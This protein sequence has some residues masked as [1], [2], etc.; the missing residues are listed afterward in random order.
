MAML[1]NQMV[2]VKFACMFQTLPVSFPILCLHFLNNII[3]PMKMQ[4]IGYSMTIFRPD[5]TWLRFS[6]IFG[7]TQHIWRLSIKWLVSEPKSSSDK[8]FPESFLTPGTTPVHRVSS[9]PHGS[10]GSHGTSTQDREGEVQSLSG[11]RGILHDGIQ[12]LARTKDIF[13][14]RNLVIDASCHIHVKYA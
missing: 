6:S 13:C 11:D 1:N 14:S 8:A 3:F 4:C 9:F 7:R 10:H 12:S 2:N 5:F